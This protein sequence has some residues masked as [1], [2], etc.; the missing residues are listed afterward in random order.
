LTAG[1]QGALYVLLFF[2]LRMEDYSLLA[3]SVILLV[4]IGALMIATRGMSQPGQPENQTGN[5]DSPPRAEG[6]GSVGR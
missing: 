1:V 4:A 5:P 3:G 2:I 6:Q